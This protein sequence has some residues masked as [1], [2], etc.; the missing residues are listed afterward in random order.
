MAQSFLYIFSLYQKDCGNN[1]KNDI[2]FISDVDLPHFV[3]FP[4]SLSLTL[5]FTHPS[6]LRFI[7]HN[8][9]SLPFNVSD[10]CHN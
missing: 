6:F 8:F 5:S 10:V 9:L 1:K 4:L 7:N 3:S 2:C